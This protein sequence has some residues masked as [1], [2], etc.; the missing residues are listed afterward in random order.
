[1]TTQDHMHA[2][3]EPTAAEC[4]DFLEQIVYF[5]DNELDE[6]DCSVVKSQVPEITLIDAIF[7][8]Q[9]SFRMG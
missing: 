9:S 3:G 6:A 5:I 2:E 1:M 4:A 8:S 7:L